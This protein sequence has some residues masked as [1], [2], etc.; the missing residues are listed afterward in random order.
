MQVPAITRSCSTWAWARA[1]PTARRS[2]SAADDLTL[3]AGQKAGDHQVAQGDRDLQ[4]A[5]RACRS[6]CKVTLRKAAHV[7]IPRP[8]GQHRAAAHPRL[9]RAQSEEL[10]RPRQLR[11]G[12]QGAH[13][14][15]RDRLRQGRPIWGMDIIVCTTARRPT[16]KRARCW[17]HSISRS[18]SETPEAIST[19]DQRSELNGE[20][21]F[22]REEQRRRRWRSSST[23]KRA[24]S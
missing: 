23:A 24:R 8:A 6:A 14:V 22:D 20:E 18:G 2:S 16:T 1:S 10:R 9:P 11:A 4:A 12:H 21:E 17:R 13:R 5:R 15:P 19:R 3:I 7:R